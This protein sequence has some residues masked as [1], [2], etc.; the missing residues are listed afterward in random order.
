ME[1]GKDPRTP[2]K[3]PN[4]PV[5]TCRKKRISQTRALKGH[6]NVLVRRKALSTHAE[7][8]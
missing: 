1:F 4:P 7:K 6:N 8:R 3:P 5:N 2:E